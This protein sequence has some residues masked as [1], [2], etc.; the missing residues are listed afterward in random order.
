MSVTMASIYITV[1]LFGFV[2][3]TTETKPYESMSKCVNSLEIHA[4][5]FKSNKRIEVQF[6]RSAGTLKISD[7][8]DKTIAIHKCQSD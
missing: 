2:T 1:H 4:S 6:S 7:T 3:K 8:V 5:R